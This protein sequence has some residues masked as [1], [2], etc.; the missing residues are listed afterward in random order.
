MA[1][2][3]SA[4]SQGRATSS[5]EHLDRL[6][7]MG[8]VAVKVAASTVVATSLASALAE[9]P[10]AEAM[11]L[12]EPVPIVRQYQ[13]FDDDLIPDEEDE[14][15]EGTS[16][17]R[18]ALKMLKYLLVAL[19][20]AAAVVFGALKG[21]A[22]IAGGVLAPPSD[23]DQQEQRASVGATEDERGVAVG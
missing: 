16:R 21:C 12:P 10:H 22:G 4:R 20:T 7:D 18:R 9:P 11:T 13:A 5:D 2:D 23:D 8:R 19:A 1:D 3:Q 6:E 14:Q 15:D 17:W